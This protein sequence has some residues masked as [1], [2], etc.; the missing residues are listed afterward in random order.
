M[1][2]IQAECRDAMAAM[3]QRLVG[4]LES[5][6]SGCNGQRWSDMDTIVRR[7]EKAVRHADR[8]ALKAVEAAEA[9]A[10]LEAHEDA[11]KELA[12]EL[13]IER[14]ENKH[15]A[16]R[17]RKQEKREMQEHEAAMEKERKE[18]E[19]LEK[20]EREKEERKKQVTER[21][22]KEELQAA[23]EDKEKRDI[24]E[25][26]QMEKA[27]TKLLTMKRLVHRAGWS[28]KDWA[29]MVQ[30]E[31]AALEQDALEVVIDLERELQQK[32][33]RK[34]DN[35]KARREATESFKVDRDV[36]GESSH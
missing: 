17:R 3:Q 11:L 33:D 13:K 4:N 15:A 19:K 8:K 9:A 32:D 29:D 34:K 10:L 26:A 23:K 1:P 36:L 30:R 22:L 18:K 7:E 21:T 24:M 2:G 16:Q 12:D 28:S 35:M 14:Q 25:V 27:T 31:G 20:K 5:W 6:Q